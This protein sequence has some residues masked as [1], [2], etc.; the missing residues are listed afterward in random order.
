M[1]ET[2]DNYISTHE[3]RH[4]MPSKT[5][6]HPIKK[7]SDVQIEMLIYDQ[8]VITTCT[9]VYLLSVLFKCIISC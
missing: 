4:A 2:P 7:L 8:N 9:Y 5:N 3:Y 1:C 6:I